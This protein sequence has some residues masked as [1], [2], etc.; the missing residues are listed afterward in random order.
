MRRASAM[1]NSACC[2]AAT[3]RLLS[4]RRAVRHA[5]ECVEVPAS[6]AARSRRVAGTRRS[7]ALVQTKAG[8]PHR[9]RAQADPDHRIAAAK[10]SAA[11]RTLLGV[12]MLKDDELVGAIV[13][14]RQEVA[15]SPTSRSSWSELRRAGRHRHRE[16]A[17]AQR[18][19]PAH[20]RSHR[21]AGAADRDLRGAEGHLQLAGRAGAGVRGHAGERDA[22]LRGQVRHAVPAA[23]ATCFR[24]VAPAWR[25]EPAEHSGRK[26]GPFSA[27]DRQ[28]EPRCCIIESRRCTFTTCDGSDLRRTRATAVAASSWRGARTLLVVPMLKDDEL[29][30]AI[31]IYRQEVRPFTDKQIELVQNFAAQAVIAIENTRLLNEL[32]QRTDDLTESLEQQTATSRC[33]KVISSSPGELEPVFEAMLENATRI[34]EA[35][36]G[37]H[38]S[39]STATSFRVVA[40]HGAPP[41][42]R[43]NCRQRDPLQPSPRYAARRALRRRSRPSTSPMCSGRSRAYRCGDRREARRRTDACLRV[44]MLKDDELIGAII[45]YRQEVRPFTDKQIELVQNFAAQAVIAI[46]NTR[47]LNELRQRTDDLTES[48]EQQTAT[49]DVLKVIS[50]SPFDLQPVFDTLVRIGGAPVRGRAAAMHLAADG[51][52][53]PRAAAVARRRSGRRPRRCKSVYPHAADARTITG[54]PCSTA[55]RSTFRTCKHD[56]ECTLARSTALRRLSEPSLGVPMLRDDEP[57]GVDQPCAHGAAAVHRQA[58]RAGDELR[59]PGGD[60]HREHA[61]VQRGAPAHRRS[62]PN[63]CSSRPPP[64]TC[65]RSSAARPFDLQTGARH[66]GRIAARLCEADYGVICCVEGDGYRYAASSRHSPRIRRDLLERN[67]IARSSPDAHVGRPRCARQD[68]SNSPMY[69]PIPNTRMPRISADRRLPHVA[70]RADAARRTS[71][72]AS[73]HCYAQRGRGRSPTSRSSWSRPSPTRR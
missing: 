14:Y 21:V 30:G 41:S 62:R 35:K 72:S 61:A 34:C 13:I 44:P 70:R 3:A 57:I 63:R 53:I 31:V 11:A 32:R 18:A 65:S 40:M 2:S 29:I 67:P 49:S 4:R 48:L 42:I 27:D 39:L 50:R 7:S 12:P 8:R 28:L 55:A 73:S 26:R 17:A 37:D 1:P 59:R 6:S 71:R 54:R 69:W 5:A 19:A 33:C 68:R 60:R 20:R 47:L 58:D 25:T 22:H 46:E 10:T 51:D 64:P 45:I 52:V 16:H 24:H 66:A 36:F 23:K 15:R 56:P 9:R 43:A 38:A